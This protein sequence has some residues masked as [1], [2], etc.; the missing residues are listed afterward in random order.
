MQNLKMI[1]EQPAEKPEH[2]DDGALWVNDCVHT[3]QGEGPLAGTP[4]VFVRLAG[5]VLQCPMCD[6]E[7][8][9][10]EL[11][12]VKTIKARVRSRAR[13]NTRL[14]VI[15]GGEPLR[16]NLEHLVKELLWTRFDVQLETNG[17]LWQEW[18]SLDSFS[19][20]RVSV[21]VSPKT[22]SMNHR[23]DGKAD[24]IKYII[25]AGHVDPDDGL[26]TN[27]LGMNIRPARSRFSYKPIYVQP[28]DEG[29]EEK[30]RVNM[31]AAVDSCLK[32]GHK[33]S[34]QIH[35]VIGLP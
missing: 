8:T 22:G 34:C 10:R 20:R 33:L 7:Y 31:E 30:N 29:D 14:V 35:K 25:Q 23:I 2:R 9:K 15:T 3:I 16:Q 27:C 11:C 5:C 26:P 28:L 1:N 17:T 6:T 19:A 21:I 4:A 18:L 12:D 13:T 24:A 32:F